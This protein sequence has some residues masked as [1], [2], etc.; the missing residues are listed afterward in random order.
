MTI[1]VISLR[2]RS[3]QIINYCYVIIDSNTKSTVLVD[4]AWEQDTIEKALAANQAKV[5]AILLT[6][7]HRDH[8]NLCESFA[9]KYNVPVY[10]SKVEKEYYDFQCTNFQRVSN[11]NSK[12]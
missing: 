3:D 12:R 6:H 1:Q 8:V 11:V 9:K 4:P 7:Y 5:S 10:M 2:V